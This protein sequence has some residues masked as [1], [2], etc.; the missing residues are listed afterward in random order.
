MSGRQKGFDTPFILQIQSF[1]S[2]GRGGI[3]KPPR[4][5]DFGIHRNMHRA[6]TAFYLIPSQGWFSRPW[7]YSHEL[8]SI[9]L[10]ISSLMTYQLTII[11]PSLT[12]SPP[13]THQSTLLTSFFVVFHILINTD[14]HE[15]NPYCLSPFAEGYIMSPCE[16]EAC[17]LKEAYRSNARLCRA[18]T[19]HLPPSRD[20][21]NGISYPP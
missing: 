19:N 17:D 1:L 4:T 13:S 9:R 14:D 3:T 16:E 8:P 21:L 20:H 10:R 18:M 11:N 6:L 2:L 15:R 7:K 5:D 12:N